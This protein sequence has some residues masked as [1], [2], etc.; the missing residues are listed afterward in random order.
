MTSGHGMKEAAN[1]VAHYEQL[2]NDALSMAHGRA[3]APGLVLF[4]R[5]GMTAWM[6]AWSPGLQNSAAASA[7]PSGA[8]QS[9][10]P[11]IRTQIAA[12]LAGIILNQQLEVHK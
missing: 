4:L 1:C 10:P 6:R 8:I 5:K 3:P 9:C 11:D 12:V 2:R 7:P